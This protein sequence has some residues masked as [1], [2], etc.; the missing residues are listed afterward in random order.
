MNQI[1]TTPPVDIA[2]RTMNDHDVRTVRTW[3]NR[4]SKFDKDIRDRSYE[5]P[6][7]Q[8]AVYL[9]KTDGDFRIFYRIDGDTITILD[10]AKKATI[11]TSGHIPDSR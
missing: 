9:L 1:V 6:G 11:Y 2:L 4:L 5:L 3:L 8:K 7:L 10:V